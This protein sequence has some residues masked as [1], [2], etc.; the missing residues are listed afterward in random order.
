MPRSRTERTPRSFS[1]REVLGV[2]FGGVD[3]AKAKGLE[4]LARSDRDMV[5][6]VVRMVDSVPPLAPELL[7][8][9]L[10]IP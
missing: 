10:R 4:A 7:F 3:A 6:N 2:S 8:W 9:L 5:S 1:C